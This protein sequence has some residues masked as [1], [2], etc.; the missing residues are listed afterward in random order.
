M[1][2]VVADFVVKFVGVVVESV[3]EQ[4]NLVG[5]VFVRKNLVEFDVAGMN[6]GYVAV[7]SELMKMG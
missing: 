6:L 4:K 1:N 3:V 2:F 7:R 5:F